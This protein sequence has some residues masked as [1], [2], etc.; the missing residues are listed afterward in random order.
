MRADEREDAYI[1][2][3]AHVGPTVPYPPNFDSFLTALLA[4]HAGRM[5]ERIFKEQEK[6]RASK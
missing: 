2:W 6:E 1:L 4:E 3:R 5:R